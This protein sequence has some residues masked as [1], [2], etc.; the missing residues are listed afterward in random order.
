MFVAR[1]LSFID[2]YIIST[3]QYPLLCLADC[4]IP[5][6]CTNYTVMDHNIF[7]VLTQS[8]AKL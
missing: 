4:V 5:L 1:V 7:S 6:L 8:M 2:T 3:A